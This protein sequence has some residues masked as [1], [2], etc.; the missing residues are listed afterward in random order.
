MTG[1]VYLLPLWLRLWHW[2]SAVAMLVLVASGLSLHYA[3]PGALRIPFD[4]ARLMHVFAG[5]ALAALW[6]GFVIGNLVGGNGRHYRFGPDFAVRCRAQIRYY[7]WDI[8]KGEDH[9]FAGTPDQK[10]NA[11][12]QVIYLV[13]MYGAMPVLMVSGLVFMQPEMLAPARLF[14]YSGLLTVALIHTTIAFI[15]TMFALGHIYLA[16][17]GR[18]PTSMIRTMITGWSER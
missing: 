11:L 18:T 8:F 10:F 17:T 12:Q 2:L 13:V 16:T 15:V 9:P 3:E 14:G 4:T 5:L 7:L 6:V 1:R